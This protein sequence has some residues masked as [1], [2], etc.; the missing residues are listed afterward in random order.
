MF[1]KLEKH[2]HLEFLGLPGSGKAS[3]ATEVINILTNNGYTCHDF[4]DIFRRSKVPNKFSAALIYYFKNIKF[5]FYLLQYTLFSSSKKLASMKYNMG[6]LFELLKLIVVLE[7]RKRSIEAPSLIL[8]D[9]G[10]MQ[11]IW[12]VTSKGGKVSKD[13]LRKCMAIKED[14]FPDVIFYIGIEPNIAVQRIS[15]RNSKCIFDHQTPSHNLELFSRQEL[16][17]SDIMEVLQEVKD[18]DI[19]ALDGCNAVND[20]TN[21]ISEFINKKISKEW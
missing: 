14:I 17:Y 11:C 21:C 12:S 5:L 8:L 6:R 4:D 10:V 3:L 19:I 2:Y 9:Q 16:N 18:I 15:S 13:T 20:N 1:A 7:I